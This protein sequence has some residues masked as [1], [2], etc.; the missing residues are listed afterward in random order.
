[1]AGT[2]AQTPLARRAGPLSIVSA[3]S[4]KRA[5]IRSSPA[6]IM[7]PT[8][9]VAQ[10][11]PGK[12]AN[13]RLVIAI[14]SPPA[15]KR[16]FRKSKPLRTIRWRRRRSRKRK[17]DLLALNLRQSS[18]NLSNIPIDIPQTRPVLRRKLED[19]LLS[20]FATHKRHLTSK[21]ERRRDGTVSG[22]G[23]VY[24][25]PSLKRSCHARCSTLLF[26]L[27]HKWKPGA[28]GALRLGVLHGI[29]CLGCC[30]DLMVGLIALGM[31]DLAFVFTAALIIF[32]EKTLP[33]S[34]RIARPL[35]VLMVAGA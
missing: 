5:T 27:M 31:M 18:R 24:Q 9:K 19:Q 22:C 32:A 26:F 23:G 21:Y 6:R 8:K 11:G 20:W 16:A 1:M 10:P 28:S 4:K 29:D 12:G 14:T 7:S 2:P 33:V 25:F 35:G 30:A 13:K 3:R 17:P 34:H 15:T